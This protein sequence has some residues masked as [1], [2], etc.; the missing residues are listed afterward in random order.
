MDKCKKNRRK[1]FFGLFEISGKHNHLVSDFEACRCKA[2][3]CDDVILITRCTFC[4]EEWMV[5][6]Y[7]MADIVLALKEWPDKFSPDFKLD[8]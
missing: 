1:L 4:N 7:G 8:K 3:R 5:Q 2:K 6:G